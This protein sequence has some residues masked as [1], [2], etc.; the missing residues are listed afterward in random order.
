MNHHLH[1]ELFKAI[2]SRKI[3]QSLQ[4]IQSILDNNY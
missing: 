1:E 3:K 4:A 2:K